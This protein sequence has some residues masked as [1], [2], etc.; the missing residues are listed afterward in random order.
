MI[1]TCLILNVLTTCIMYMHGGAW[2]VCGAFSSVQKKFKEGQKLLGMYLAMAVAKAVQEGNSQV[3]VT[4]L[5]LY[6]WLKMIART[7]LFQA[8]S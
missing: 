4:F 1:L 2:R 6:L 7:G 3:S 8:A 5:V